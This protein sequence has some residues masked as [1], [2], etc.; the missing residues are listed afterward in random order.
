M[1]LHQLKGK[2]ILIVGYGIEGKSVEAFLKHHLPDLK[3]GITDEQNGPS[4]LDQQKDYDLAIKSP[5][6]HKSLITIPYT[7]ATN[8]FF[9]NCLGITIGITGS[10][11]KSTTTALIYAILQEAGKNTHLVGNIT[12]KL[13][14]I[15]TPMLTKLLETNS[16]NDY[17]VCELSSFQL[18][19]IAYS[20]HISVITSFF[21]EH[22]NFHGNMENYWAAKSRIVKHAKHTDYFVFNQTDPRITELSQHSAAKAIPFLDELPFPENTIPLLGP[23]NFA[24]V[25]AACAVAD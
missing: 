18:D 20:P 24:N 3:V 17:W 15:G 14:A 7:T 8:I 25:K 10:K 13:D 23:H 12:H 9:A 19:D 6:I 21:P 22:L 16:K 1:K 5:G 4:Y 11:G 2:K